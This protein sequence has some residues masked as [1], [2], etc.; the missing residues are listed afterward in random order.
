MARERNEVLE[1][2][3]AETGWSRAEAASAVVRTAREVGAEKLYRTTHSHISKW[4]AGHHPRGRAPR[5]LAEA[6]SRRLGREIAVAEIGLGVEAAVGA[7]EWDADSVTALAE[8]GEDVHRREFIKDTVY[9]VV[10]QTVPGRDWWLE[11]ARAPAQRL[12]WAGRTVSDADI[13]GVREFTKAFSALDQKLG[14]G[15]GRAALRTHLHTQVVPLLSGSFSTE[16]ARRDLYSAAA[17]MTY[18]SGW[19][20]FD[21][22]AHRDAQRYFMLAAKLAAEAGDG[23]LAGHVLRAMAHQAVDIGHP[24][25]ALDLASASMDRDRHGRANPREKALLGIVHARA[26]AATGDRRGALTAISRAEHDLARDLGDAPERVSFFGEASL[27]HETACAMRDLGCLQDAE[28]HFRRSV[29]L[30]PRDLY[31]R[32][33]SVTLGYMG[34]VQIRQGRMDEA[35]SVWDEALDAMAGVHSGRARDVIVRMRSDLSPFRHR[36]GLRVRQLDQRAGEM[37]R[38]IG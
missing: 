18:L 5:I 12:A 38:T 27:A 29:E 37:L 9:S 32:T 7:V 17:E 22:S 23:P 15:S 8:L 11:A 3:L 31:R 35:L 19:M 33:H 28:A 13:V 30:R 6:L 16:R 26:L 20:A 4:V 2:L 10:G 21:A 36:G 1:G 24:A 25:Q 14:G 34:A